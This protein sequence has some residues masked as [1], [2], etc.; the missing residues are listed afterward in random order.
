MVEKSLCIAQRAIE[1]VGVE[2]TSR[3]YVLENLINKFSF[4]DDKFEIIIWCAPQVGET[5]RAYLEKIS[6]DKNGSFNFV[7]KDNKGRLY[8][9][10]IEIEM[11]SGRIYHNK[12]KIIEETF[13]AVIESLV[14]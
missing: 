14:D 13:I 4:F 11:P 8:R 5:L 3:E 2:T 10:D 9:E 7:V 6:C 12:K 1:A